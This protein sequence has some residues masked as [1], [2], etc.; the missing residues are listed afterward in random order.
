[1]VKTEMVIGPPKHCRNQKILL[2]SFK[3]TPRLML[4]GFGLI[5][6]WKQCFL[7]HPILHV[8]DLFL[9][10]LVLNWYTAPCVIFTI[11][12]I[13]GSGMEDPEHTIWRGERGFLGA[14]LEVGHTGRGGW[15]WWWVRWLHEVELDAGDKEREGGTWCGEKGSRGYL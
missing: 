7:V 10:P 15:C 12:S 4:G 11:P 13:I 5:C 3:L 2:D 6:F 8:W 1:M 9:H 14:E